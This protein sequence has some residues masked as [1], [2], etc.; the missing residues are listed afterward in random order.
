GFERLIG[1]WRTSLSFAPFQEYEGPAFGLVVAVA[2]A[3][4]IA[5]A[6]V[7]FH[8]ILAVVAATAF[9]AAQLLLPVF[10]TRPSLAGHATAFIVVGAGLLVVGLALDARSA[11]RAAF[12]WHLVGLTTLTTGLAYH[13]FRNAT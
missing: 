13:A 2:V 9:A 5:F 1:V 6:I 10:V 12:W 11:R 7:R 4:L 8:F 3:G